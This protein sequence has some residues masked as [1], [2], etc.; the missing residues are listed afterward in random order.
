M[1]TWD[2][3][4]YLKF[5]DERTRPA[6]DL[7]ARITLQT[8]QRVIDLGCGPGNSTALLA[9]RYPNADLTGLDSSAEMLR[10]ANASGVKAKWIEASFDA[11]KPDTPYDLIYAN[12]AFQ[13]SDDPVTLTQRLFQ[14]LP[15]DGVLAFQVPQNF[16][17]A[18]HVEVRAAVDE[19]PYRAKLIGA[20]Q[21]DPGFAK[22]A[23][24]ARALTPLGAELDIWTTEYLHFLSGADPVFRWMSGTGLR[25]FTQRLQ[26]EERAHFEA[27]VCARLAKAYPPESEGRTLFPFKRLF[28]IATKT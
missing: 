17:Q 22:A 16:D 20:R 21:Y 26:G 9:A 12:A 19:S 4:V 24:Y 27:A 18:S 11:W 6:A 23:D 14:S 15:Q 28:V 7:L 3:N 25:P 13:W 8:P 10:D 2:P 1:S 5:G